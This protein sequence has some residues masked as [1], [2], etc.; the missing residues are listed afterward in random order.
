MICPPEDGSRDENY[1]GS[2]ISLRLFW[3]E[4]LDYGYPESSLKGMHGLLKAFFILV[5]LT[6]H[7]WTAAQPQEGLKRVSTVLATAG[8]PAARA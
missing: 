3:Q 8:V 6:F 2:R 4:I 5:S 7:R 1:L